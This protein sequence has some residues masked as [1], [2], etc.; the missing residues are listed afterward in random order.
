MGLQE[1]DSIQFAAQCQ[2]GDALMVACTEGKVAT[3]AVKDIRES[4]T[5]TA[6]GVKVKRLKPGTSTRLMPPP[7]L[8]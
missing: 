2:Q 4:M 6:Q 5:R 7:I 3:C 1:G 8:H